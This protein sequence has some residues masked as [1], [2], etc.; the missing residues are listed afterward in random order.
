MKPALLYLGFSV[1]VIVIGLC[2]VL[3]TQAPADITLESYNRIE[4]DMHAAVFCHEDGGIA[5]V[6][7][8]DAGR[9]RF[10]VCRGGAV[11]GRYDLTP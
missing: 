2:A 1:L 9:H 7:Q 6:F 10:V 8:D 11:S 5:A 4:P 3:H